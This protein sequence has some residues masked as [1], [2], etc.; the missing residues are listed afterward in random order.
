VPLSDELALLDD[1]AAIMAARFGDRLVLTR[2][3]E[4]GAAGALVPP[5]L[6]QP[7]VENAVRHG[8][9]ARLGSG[10]ITV[11]ARRE[12]DVLRL[13]VEDDGG[14]AAVADAAGF[15]MG[16]RTA[17]ERLALLYGD[18]AALAAGAVEGG[19]RVTAALPFRLTPA[20]EPA[21]PVPERAEG[22][23]VRSAPAPA[24]R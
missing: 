23:A 10:A 1:Y 6:L 17:R 14:R 2:E 3:I 5:F 13:E 16:L 22:P 7:L 18:S 21:P 4:D 11:R 24:R 20:G 9:A 15:G 8:N 12:G 19:F